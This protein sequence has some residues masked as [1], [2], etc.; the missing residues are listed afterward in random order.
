MKNSF[1]LPCYHATL[2]ALLCTDEASHMV[3]YGKEIK[4]KPFWQSSLLHSTF[5]NSNIK[6]SV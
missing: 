6:E 3:L 2:D 4:L 1:S 5:I